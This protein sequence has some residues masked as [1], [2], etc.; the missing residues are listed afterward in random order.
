MQFAIQ[1]GLHRFVYLLDFASVL[2]CIQLQNDIDNP[3]YE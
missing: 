1:Q 3:V 2:K